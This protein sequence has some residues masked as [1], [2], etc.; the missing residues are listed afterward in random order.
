MA[1][2][3]QKIKATALEKRQIPLHWWTC[4]FIQQDL[5]KMFAQFSPPFQKISETNDA[6]FESPNNQ[7]RY[8]VWYYSEGGHTVIT[9]KALFLLKLL[10]S[11]S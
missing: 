2:C 8:C 4:I 10:W 9:E 6:L 11:L 1:L 3:R 7:E 5:R